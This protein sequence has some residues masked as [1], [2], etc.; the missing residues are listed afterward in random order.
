MLGSGIS[1]IGNDL[2]PQD[3]LEQIL[4]SIK[5]SDIDNAYN[6][7]INIVLHES[8]NILIYSTL[9]INFKTNYYGKQTGNYCA[10]YVSEPFS[11]S[12]LNA[13]ATKDFVA[14]N[15][16]RMWKYKDASFL[17]VDSHDKN[18]NVRDGSD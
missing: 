15:Q 16:L 1:R 14:Y 18:Y 5:L 7:S 3:Y 10:F 8:R 2:K 9:K 12:N 13:F 11:E 6:T 17:F 4:N